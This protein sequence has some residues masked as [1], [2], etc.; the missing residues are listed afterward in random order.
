MRANN[1][2]QE[3]GSIGAQGRRGLGDEATAAR[4]ESGEYFSQRLA[5]I[6]HHHQQAGGDDCIHRAEGFGESQH[7]GFDKM[8]V[9]QAAEVR[10]VLGA[11]KQ[12]LGKIDPCDANLRVALRQTAGIETGATGY[13]QKVGFGAGLGAR[14][15]G[16]GDGGGV[17]AEQMFTTECVK[18]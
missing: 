8:T 3:S 4:A 9:L 1:H 10:P 2:M 12:S 14:P 7:I 16:V 15:K 18:P 6:S 11:G 5:A 17:I 13:F